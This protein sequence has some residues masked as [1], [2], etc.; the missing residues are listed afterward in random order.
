MGSN[1]EKLNISTPIMKKK[2]KKTIIYKKFITFWVHQHYFRANCIVY[3]SLLVLDY[4][5]N[6]NDEIN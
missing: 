5:A 6:I 1:R 3:T 4:I 2:K